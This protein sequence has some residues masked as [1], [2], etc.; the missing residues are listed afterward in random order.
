MHV[1]SKITLAS[2]LLQNI[3]RANFTTQFDK[4]EASANKRML[5]LKANWEMDD[6]P[7]FS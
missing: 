2:T 5:S 3:L 7:L 4:G 6:L 1:L